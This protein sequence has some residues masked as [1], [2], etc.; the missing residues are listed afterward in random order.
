MKIIFHLL[1]VS[2]LLLA[3]PAKRTPTLVQQ[4][5]GTTFYIVGYGDERYNYA[6]TT[7]GYVVVQGNDNFWYYADLNSEG[8]FIPTNIKVD[9]KQT[10][11]SLGKHLR[12]SKSVIAEKKEAHKVIQNTVIKSINKSNPSL[13]KTQTTVKHVLILCVKFSDLANTYTASSFQS[14]VNDDNWKSG[15]GG[16]SKYYKEVSYNNVSIQADYQEWVLAANPSTYYAKNNTDYSTH[17]QELIRQAID[18]AEANGVNFAQYDNDGDGKV[19]GLF[20]VHAGKGA[21]EGNQ[22]QYIWSHQSSLG[23]GYSRVYDGKTVSQYIIMP[24]IYST[25]HV[26]IGVFCHEYGHMLGLP[27]LYDTDGSTNGDS[28]GVG[29]WCLMAGGSWGGN[30]STPERPA[31]MSAYCK[32]LLG[33]TTPTVISSSQSLSIPQAETN[34][35]MY[36]I[37]LDNNQSDE[38]MLIENRQKT[39]FDLNL[40]NS[41]LLIYHVDKNLADIWPGSNDINVTSTHL[42]VKVY[43]ADGLEQMATGVNRGNSGDPYPGS[44]N[45]TTLSASTTPNTKLWNGTSS[46]VEINSISASSATMSAN[47]VIPI[48]YGYGQQFYR[49]YLGYGYG[50][51]GSNTGY[52]MVK[53]TPSKTGKLSGVRVYSYANTYTSLSASAYST[54]SGGALSSQLGNTVN[55]ASSTIDNYVQLNF[56][57]AIDVVQNIPIYIRIY[58]VK[59]SGGYAVPIDLT[60]PITGNSYYSSSALT[61]YGVLSSYDIPVRVVFQSST[62][63]PVELISFYASSIDNKINLKWQ[64]ATEMNNDGFE[65]ERAYQ[66]EGWNKVAFLQ[67][68]GNSNVIN[69]YEFT[70]MPKIVGIYKYRLK[71]VDLDGNF[72]YSE[73]ISATINMPRKFELCQNYPNP[74]NPTTRITFVTP[75]T[76]DIKLTVYNLL[77]KQVRT[78]FDGKAEAGSHTV[79]FDASYLSSGIYICKLIG[80]GIEKNIKL[81][82]LK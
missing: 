6:E 76:S 66:N 81:T 56:S 42:G 43:E 78:L 68:H 49:Q 12:E 5:D 17:V 48:Y 45:V 20:I 27:D 30:G 59:A 15:V 52:G 10:V 64:T 44:S 72:K 65:I 28:E 7:D 35:L 3:M 38:Y 23:S 63:M 80:Q 24:E 58:F 13:K 60:T 47:A 31:H 1:I 67:G 14:M 34:S 32:E 70:D 25:G 62:P 75:Y 8:R 46:G 53:C 22:G 55:G 57:P 71:Q 2:S 41:G 16:M 26:D 33:Y 40:A 21:E 37:W 18:A 51:S 11:R 4:P 77:G 54:F 82:L 79:Q 19:D 74:F 50:S 61:S 9:E 36:K 73:E 39:G 69:N 29:N